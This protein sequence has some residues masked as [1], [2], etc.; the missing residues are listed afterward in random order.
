MRLIKPIGEFLDLNTAFERR[1]QPFINPIWFFFAWNRK[2]DHAGFV[3]SF[4]FL[5]FSFDFSITDIRHWD[6]ANQ[7]HFPGEYFYDSPYGW[8]EQCREA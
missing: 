5:W 4:E 1:K 7:K 8:C 6:N 3:C 2:C